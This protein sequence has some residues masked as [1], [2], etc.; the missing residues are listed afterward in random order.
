MSLLCITGLDRTGKSTVATHYESLGYEVVHLSAPDKKYTQ[1]G[2]AGPSYFDDYIEML[3]SFNG[4]NV[5]MDRFWD[6]ELVWPFIYNREPLLSEEEI[7]TIREIESAMGVNYILMHDP[8]S[9]AH[10]QRCVDNKEPLTRSQ[11][12]HANAAYQKMAAKYGFEIKTL[13]DFTPIVLPKV[14]PVESA[15]LMES[16]ME[17]KAI[18]KTPEQIKLEKANALNEI[19]SKRIIK[20]KGEYYDQIEKDIKI[21]LNNKLGS[22][23][24]SNILED[25]FSQNEIRILK[26][27]VDRL[28]EKESK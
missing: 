6:G 27:L 23:L 28:K 17:I 3:M 4:K 22:L 21:Y 20:Q 26:T 5:V 18:N 2:Y 12:I 19:L 1:P 14:S 15:P 16:H 25:T 9:K 11:F 24:G 10:W 13:S 7:E 8:D